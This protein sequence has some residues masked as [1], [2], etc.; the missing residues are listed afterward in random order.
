MNILVIKCGSSSQRF[1][2]YQAAAGSTPRVSRPKSP[3]QIWLIPTDEEPVI[4][5]EVLAQC[6]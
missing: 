6:D 4:A 5:R 2:V 1:K 3:T